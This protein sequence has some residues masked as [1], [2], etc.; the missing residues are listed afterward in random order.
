M[1]DNVLIDDPI[2]K[3]E[4]KM[5][6]PY[7]RLNELDFVPYS[8]RLVNIIGGKYSNYFFTYFE[9][10]YYLKQQRKP[11]E[12]L[13]TDIE[14]KPRISWMTIYK[15]I[16]I[17]TSNGL[18]LV[19]VKL[20]KLR[21]KEEI[22][23][24]K[25]ESRKFTG[26]EKLFV[27]IYLK[28]MRKIDKN[29]KIENN[30]KDEF[31]E[32]NVFDRY[33]YYTQSFLRKSTFLMSMRGGSSNNLNLRKK[34]K[35]SKINNNDNSDEEEEETKKN[36]INRHKMMKK[37]R[38]LRIDTL[39][40]IE[41]L[42]EL[43]LKEKQKKYKTI[44]S[45][46]LDVFKNDS[47]SKQ[48]S[49]FYDSTDITSNKEILNIKRRPQSSYINRRGDN[50]SE[51]C[52]KIINS[53]S[54]N[55]NISTNNNNISNNISCDMKKKHSNFLLTEEA[56]KMNDIFFT[57][58]NIIDDK[59]F[60]FPM[61]TIRNKNKNMKTN[62]KNKS[63]F[64]LTCS[65]FNTNNNY[66][67]LSI[68]CDNKKKNNNNKCLNI[69]ENLFKVSY[70][71]KKNNYNYSNTIPVSY[72]YLSSTNSYYKKDSN[73]NKVFSE[74]NQIIDESNQIYKLLNPSV[75]NSKTTK[76]SFDKCNW[77]YLKNCTKN[78]YM[79]KNQKVKNRPKSGIQRPLYL[80][81]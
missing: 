33:K 12:R 30:I 26:D 48:K 57:T 31:E 46:Y 37:V 44:K 50:N 6:T 66:P 16:Q 32:E 18:P 64:L 36:K 24:I 21:A 4:E 75:K 2:S 71:N 65:N 10:F 58:K 53:S 7:E 45:R 43:K 78:L 23:F 77:G 40:N 22:H 20:L 51:L 1:L 67:L 81:T 27:R 19:I 38:Q 13:S 55:N 52:I 76:R 11:P 35:K 41:S 62:F 28:K 54:S 73:S 79:R 59:F 68:N 47:R 49:R 72:K 3:I 29:L 63:Q 69:N 15:E 61:T 70:S 34:I 8:K 5:I 39:V 17:I 42:N 25:K 74:C 9:N 80:R 14:E 60:L 56:K